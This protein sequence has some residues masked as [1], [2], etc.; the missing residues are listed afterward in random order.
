VD[1][2]SDV[3]NALTIQVWES[4]LGLPIEADVPRPN[5]ADLNVVGMVGITGGWE[6]SVLVRCTLP[7]ARSITETMFGM[8]PGEAEPEE[9]ADALGEIANMIG[10]NLKSLVPGPSQLSLPMVADYEHLSFPQSEECA[11][12]AFSTGSEPMLVSVLRRAAAPGH[13]ARPSHAALSHH[14]EQTRH[15]DPDR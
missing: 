11:T 7:L 9:I 15:E 13:G 5:D 8:D 12:A 3:I 6:G 10:G 1:P 14:E 2:T 4:I